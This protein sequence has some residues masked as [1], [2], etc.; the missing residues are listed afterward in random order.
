MKSSG[1][2]RTRGFEGVYEFTELKH[3]NFGIDD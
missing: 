3:I 2:G 1:A